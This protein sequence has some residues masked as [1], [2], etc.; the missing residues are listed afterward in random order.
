MKLILFFVFL[1][2]CLNASASIELSWNRIEACTYPEDKTEKFLND[3]NNISEILEDKHI[4]KSDYTN[5]EKTLTYLIAPHPGPIS[6]EMFRNVAGCSA[7]M[8][9][10]LI[11]SAASHVSKSERKDFGWMACYQAQFPKDHA[12]RVAAIKLQSCMNQ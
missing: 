11:Q 9:I 4:N 7:K 1:F 6:M 3:F 10:V 12:V 5:L 8:R 2:F